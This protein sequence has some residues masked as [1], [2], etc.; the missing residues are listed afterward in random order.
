MKPRFFAVVVW[1]V[2][3]ATL[4]AQTPESFFPHHIGD[5]W[6][7][8]DLNTGQIF[9]MVLTNDS[10][11]ADGSHYLFYNNSSEPAY[12]IA[13]SLNDFQGSTNPNFNYLRYKLVADS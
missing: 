7:Y 5:R 11:G 12:R 8:Q 9:T 6:D 13:T 10:I 1:L 2:L 4:N 3:H